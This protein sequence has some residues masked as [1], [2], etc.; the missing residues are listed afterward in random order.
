MASPEGRELDQLN[1]YQLCQLID[2]AARL[3]MHLEIEQG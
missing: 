2:D 3:L 1:Q